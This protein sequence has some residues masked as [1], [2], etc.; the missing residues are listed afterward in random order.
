ME[1]ESVLN[2]DDFN[3]FLDGYRE[4][5]T[6]CGVMVEDAVTG[7]FYDSDLYKVSDL[8]D[9]AIVESQK[10]CA[11]FF[12][13]NLE[14]MQKTGNTDFSSFGHDFYL[15]RNGHGTGCFDRGYGKTGD[16]LQDAARVYGDASLFVDNAG[17]LYFF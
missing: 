10:D 7:D 11:N 13:A 16:E 2:S 4:C 1:N 12:E 3:D 14:L 9:S 8:S 17:K 5:A 6:W 15:S